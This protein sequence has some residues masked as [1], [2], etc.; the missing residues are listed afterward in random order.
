[1]PRKTGFG[2]S[3]HKQQPWHEALIKQRER[4]VAPSIAE[5]A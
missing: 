5:K 4:V 2:V 1:M 3:L